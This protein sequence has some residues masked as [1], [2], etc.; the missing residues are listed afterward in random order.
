VN[1]DLL[2]EKRKRLHSGEAYNNEVWL[3]GINQTWKRD[4]S[5]VW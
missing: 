2:S 5:R 3:W 1:N 4:F